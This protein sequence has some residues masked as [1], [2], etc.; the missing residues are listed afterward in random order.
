MSKD[1]NLEKYSKEALILFIKN[2]YLPRVDYEK[3]LNYF[4]WRAEM[5]RLLKQHQKVLDKIRESSESTDWDNTEKAIK[6]LTQRNKLMK[7]SD[8]ILKKLSKLRSDYD[9]ETKEKIAA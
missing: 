3:S 7:Q 9:K 2:Y 6:A 1:L 5:E 4:E 8:R